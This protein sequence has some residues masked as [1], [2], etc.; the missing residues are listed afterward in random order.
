M[1]G[2]Y[3]AGAMTEVAAGATGSGLLIEAASKSGNCFYIADNE[4][5][6]PPVIAYAEGA[7]AC[8]A[9]ANVTIPATQGAVNAGNAGAHITAAGAIA[10]TNW[11]TS[12]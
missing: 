4:L 2:A 6:T 3:A 5:V 11:Y 1:A 10:N 7:T 8:E 12:W 9:V